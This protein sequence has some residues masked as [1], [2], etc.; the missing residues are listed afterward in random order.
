[1]SK[2]PLSKI[3]AND[4]YR[5]LARALEEAGVRHHE[6][7]DERP[8]PKV[9]FVYAGAP[10][11]FKFAGTPSS[12]RT[13]R[14]TEAKLRRMLRAIDA[15]EPFEV[16]K[17]DDDGLDDANISQEAARIEAER[18]PI[19]VLQ[20]GEALAD[21]RDVAAYFGRR[22]DDVLRSYR[23]LH[24]STDF[25]ARNFAEFKINDLTGESLSH[26]MMTKDGF[27]FLAMGFTGEKAGAFKERYIAQFNAME[28][29]LRRRDETR[30]ILTPPTTAEA[31][32][33]AFTMIAQTERVQAQQAQAIAALEATMARV[34]TAQVVLSAR[35]ANAEA[36]S[37]IRARIGKAFGLSSAVIDEV[38]RQSPYAPK[39]AGMV[40]NDHVDADGAL[41]AV[42]WQK[43][44]TKTFERFVSECA[45]ATQFMF[46][47]PFIEG[48]F[49]CTRITG[50]L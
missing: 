14:E 23:N 13:P 25:R 24:C 50:A 34:E 38:M 47:H 33:H 16:S 1:M 40:R 32:A 18:N 37:H 9:M 41:Y 42:Y 45:A 21:S 44:V 5:F 15:G 39:P 35:P 17:D 19:V 48:R 27:V 31:F 26:V 11:E 30:A 4:T 7:V 29:E 12:V 49:R 6:V 43:D 20:D 22:H 10:R 36:I 8:H 2:D 3:R 46:T 28:A